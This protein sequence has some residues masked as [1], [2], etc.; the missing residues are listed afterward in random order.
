MTPGKNSDIFDLL[1]RI[2]TGD[3]Q[4]RED[5]LSEYMPFVAK[6]AMNMCKRPLEWENSDE[7]SISLIA[8]N[9]AVDTYDLDK[10]VPFLPYARIVIQNRL[11]DH[12][13]KEARHNSDC[14]LETETFEGKLLSPAEVQSAW[15]DYRNRTIEDERREEL[16]DYEELLKT[17]GIDFEALAEVSPKHTDSRKSLFRAAA[18]LVRDRETMDYLLKKKQLPVSKL[19]FKTGINRKTIEKGRKF[20]IATALVFY[21]PMK[22]PYLRSYINPDGAH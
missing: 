13:R 4:V 5:F 15:E 11:K 16:E 9:D 14:P 2:Q 22:F 3:T 17:F 12:F 8:F 10:K 18:M 6:T 1:R 7:L 21:Y 19:M 20:I